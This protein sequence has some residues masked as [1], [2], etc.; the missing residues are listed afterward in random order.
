[1]PATRI[2]RVVPE[3][4]W[5]FQNGAGGGCH[6]TPNN[7]GGYELVLLSATCSKLAGESLTVKSLTTK[8]LDDKIFVCKFSKYVKSKP[9]QRL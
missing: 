6:L 4:I 2:I 8:K 3:V 7:I 1:M 5:P 9:Y